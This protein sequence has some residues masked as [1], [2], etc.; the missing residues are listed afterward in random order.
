MQMTPEQE[1]GL[2]TEIQARLSGLGEPPQLGYRV[3]LADIQKAI[4]MSRFGEPY[5]KFA[6]YRDMIL[7]D[8]NLQAMIGQRIMS[9]MGQTE[10][11]EPIDKNNPEDVKAAE[12]IQE[13]IKEVDSTGK[14]LIKWK[15][16][17]QAMSA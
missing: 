14:G 4:Q 6:L 10:T 1:R 17:L 5:F 2:L 3:T 7:N 16:F 15:D 11:I 9:F 8:P 13:M 12:V